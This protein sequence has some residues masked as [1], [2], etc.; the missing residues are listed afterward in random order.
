MW[1]SRFV[2]VGAI[3]SRLG[4]LRATGFI[5]STLAW[6]IALLDGAETKRELG[7]GLIQITRATG[8]LEALAVLRRS[9]A[10]CAHPPTPYCHAQPAQTCVYSISSYLH[11][12]QCLPLSGILHIRDKTAPAGSAPTPRIATMRPRLAACRQMSRRSN[13][14]STTPRGNYSHRGSRC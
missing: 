11:R 2:G 3:Y 7:L 1:R 12:F 8:K 9:I 13:S 4:F 10:L 5:F 6:H 14:S